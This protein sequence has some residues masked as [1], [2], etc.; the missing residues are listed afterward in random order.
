MAA[1]ELEL[2]RG[3]L[4]LL[5]LRTLAPIAMHGYAVAAA[6]KERSGG[7]LLVEE[8]ALYPALH[9]LEERGLVEAEWGVSENNRRARYYA[10]T[11][12]GA[13]RLRAAS[14]E[15]DRYVQA[16]GRVLAPAPLGGE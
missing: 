7:E 16:V 11:R 8:G 10:L 4:D 6:I 5:I 15:W 9:R 3:T 1:D 12:T 14:A 2:M 13:K